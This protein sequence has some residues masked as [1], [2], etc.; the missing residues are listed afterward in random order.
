MFLPNNDKIFGS[1]SLKID[2]PANFDKPGDEGA[3]YQEY[4]ISRTR[5]MNLDLAESRCNPDKS[6]ENTTE[7]ITEYLENR[8]G[9]SMDLQGTHYGLGK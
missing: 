3:Y 2:S 5:W 1:Y 6:G 8:I 7:C 4:E 9:C